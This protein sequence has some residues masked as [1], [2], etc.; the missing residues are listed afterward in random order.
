MP[1]FRDGRFGLLLDYV[2]SR[3]VRALVMAVA[4][5]GGSP[6]SA[7]ELQISVDT[8]SKS[9]EFGWVY[10][11]GLDYDFLEQLREKTPGEHIWRRMFS[12]QSTSLSPEL[13][14]ADLPSVAGRYEI[15]ETGIRFVPRFTLTQGLSYQVSL[16]FDGHQPASQTFTLEDAARPTEARAA[17]EAIYPSAQSIP[18][19]TLRLYVHFSRPMQRGQV[20][21]KIRLVDESDEIVP[22]TFIVGPLGELWDRDQRRLTLLF[23]PGRLKRGVGPNRDLGP[24]L[25]TGGRRTLIVDGTFLDATGHPI[26]AAYRRT[27]EIDDAIRKAVAPQ[28]WVVDAPTSGAL[29]P[30]RLRFARALDSGMLSRAIRVI[31]AEDV[32]GHIAVAAGETEWVFTPAAPWSAEEY[33]VRVANILEDVS[34]NNVRTPMD[35]TMSAAPD[36]S[37]MVSAGVS[38]EI[39]FTPTTPGN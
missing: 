35:V 32:D 6:V 15:L 18:E 1:M 2:K 7:T 19:N 21:E 8:K 26:G 17:I 5:S 38:T 10:V 22:D 11:T 9:P 29:D 39:G 33:T 23:D 28:R 31:D 13:D 14:G 12:V 16:K 27:Y 34:G 3:L 25:K 30:L 4:F 20:A 24:A 36:A 37:T